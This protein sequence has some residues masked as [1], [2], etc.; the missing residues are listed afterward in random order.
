[1]S[2]EDNKQ[3]S[4][5]PAT[6]KRKTVE[7]RCAELARIS[8]L[9]EHSPLPLRIEPNVEGVSLVEWA[10]DNK[11][12]IA[13]GLL[14]H[15]GILFRNFR[16]G[17]DDF[18]RFVRAIA[19]ELLNYHDRSSPRHRVS[20]D[21]F[22]STDYP[23]EHPIFLHN[24]NSYSHT[25]PLKIFFHCVQSALRG[26]ETPIADVREVFARISPSLRQRFTEKKVM[27]V[28]NFGNGLGLS[29]QEAFQTNDRAVVESTCRGA[30][31][32]FEWK[33]NNRLKTR[34]VREAIATHPV[35][36]EKLWFNHALFFH[37]STLTSDVRE[38]LFAAGFTEE[39]FPYNTYYGDGTPFEPATLDEVRDAYQQQAVYFSWQAGDILMLDNMLAA[40]GRM[41]YSGARRILVAM[42]GASGAAIAED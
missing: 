27:Y 33:A 17:R 42:A 7:L 19:G 25:W 36:K 4:P 30:G 5:G 29:W 8:P 26:G 2:Y 21:V 39:D 20:G 16:V 6:F 15:G 22:T 23:A 24:E 18:A 13:S 11:S 32:E 41:P 37:A 28:R 35:T 14:K 1:M 34:Q 31:I 12:V 40:H 9:L 10:V 38:T 3:A